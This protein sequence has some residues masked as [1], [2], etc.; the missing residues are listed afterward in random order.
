MVYRELHIK[1]NFYKDMDKL[2]IA[3]IYGER[4]PYHNIEDCEFY[5]EVAKKRCYNRGCKIEIVKFWQRVP[6]L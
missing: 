1:L 5:N 3:L 2:L 6:K 4:R